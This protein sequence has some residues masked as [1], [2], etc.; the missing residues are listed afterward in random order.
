MRITIDLEGGTAQT[1]GIIQV[2]QQAKLQPQPQ[3]VEDTDAGP[4]PNELIEA[5]ALEGALAPIMSSF[6]PL[7]ELDVTA[8]RTPAAGPVR[9]TWEPGTL[10][11][12]RR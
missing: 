9:G 5:L 12:K 4:P 2:E 7:G 8:A 10:M 1:A 3:P 6:Q 11:K